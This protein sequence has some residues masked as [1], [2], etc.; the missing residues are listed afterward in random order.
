MQGLLVVLA[1][2]AAFGISLGV[3]SATEPPADTSTGTPAVSWEDVRSQLAVLQRIASQSCSF[4]VTHADSGVFGSRYTDAVAEFQRAFDL[5]RAGGEPRPADIPP[6]APGLSSLEARF[7]PDILAAT[8]SAVAEPVPLES[9]A[10]AGADFAGLPGAQVLT[11]E[12]LDAAAFIAGW[13][14]SPGWWPD[15]RLIVNCESGRNIFAYNGSDPNGGSYGLAQLNGSQHFDR[16][17]ENFEYRFDPIV[18][19]RTALWLRT[20]RGHFGGEGGWKT[21]SELYGIP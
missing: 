13:P 1:A 21:C 20:V 3:L 18:N 2:F 11:L 8:A 19:L 15:M 4:M 14:M 10:P 7:C 5:A 6:A 12:Q 16:A 17:G 9:A